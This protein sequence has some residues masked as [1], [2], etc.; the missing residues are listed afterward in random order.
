MKK[1]WLTITEASKYVDRDTS[2][3]RR[4]IENGNMFKK[5][6]TRKI[7]YLWQIKKSALDREYKEEK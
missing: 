2:T 1:E 4:N 3:L 5:G 6:E 7:S